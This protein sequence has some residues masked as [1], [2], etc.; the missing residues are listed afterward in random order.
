MFKIKIISNSIIT[1]A[2]QFATEAECINWYNSEISNF[3]VSHTYVVENIQAEIDSKNAKEY[4]INTDWYIIRELDSG[5]V[6]PEE[7]K[8]ARAAARLKVI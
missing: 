4:L 6:C 7:I 3:P 1:N 2:G 5:V 8:L